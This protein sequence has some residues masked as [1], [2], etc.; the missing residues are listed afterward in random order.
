MIWQ[1]F[2]K[3]RASVGIHAQKLVRFLWLSMRA[4]LL[5]VLVGCPEKPTIVTAV[6]PDLAAG[7]QFL[8]SD[9]MIH[10]KANGAITAIRPFKLT[11]TSVGAKQ[12]SAEFVM[13]GMEMGPSRYRFISSSGD[14]WI[15]DVMLPI[16]VQ[17]RRDWYMILNLDDRQVRVPFTSQ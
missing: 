16:C 9:R 15:A 10:A 2:A 17:G 3:W 5:F 4:S 1:W 7:C 6:C 8:L 13:Q 14:T 12:V 11:I